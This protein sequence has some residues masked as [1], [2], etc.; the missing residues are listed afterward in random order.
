MFESLLIR[1]CN[2]YYNTFNE[3]RT[4]IIVYNHVKKELILRIFC[5]IEAERPF[6]ILQKV[7]T[8]VSK[9]FLHLRV[10]HVS[11][12]ALVLIFKILFIKFVKLK[13]CN[14]Y[15]ACFYFCWT[16]FIYNTVTIKIC[17]NFLKI[18]YH[19]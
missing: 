15:L 5:Y 19:I 8:L 6:F 3:Q 14:M 11:F 2:N 7:N 18:F 13:N 4:M 1:L 12:W 16:I 9:S 17:Q 10:V